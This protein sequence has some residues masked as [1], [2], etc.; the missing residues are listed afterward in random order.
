MENLDY[1]DYLVLA[2]VQVG[3]GMEIRVSQLVVELTR[4]F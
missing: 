4:V 3:P 1:L 2:Q